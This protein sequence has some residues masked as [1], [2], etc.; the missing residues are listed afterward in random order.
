M[1]K[2]PS[3][4]ASAP[5]STS[6]SPIPWLHDRGPDGHPA[7]VLHHDSRS[8]IPMRWVTSSMPSAAAVIGGCSLK[9]GIG[10]MPGTVLGC[11]FISTVIDSIRQDSRRQRDQLQ[12]LRRSRRRHRCCARCRIQPKKYRC[13]KAISRIHRLGCY[14]VFELA[15][16]LRGRCSTKT[17]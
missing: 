10:T 8:L 3:S 16:G 15:G 13:A 5:S 6:G 14:S 12:N 2:R 11:L 1:N 9:G 7:A 4:A 17:T